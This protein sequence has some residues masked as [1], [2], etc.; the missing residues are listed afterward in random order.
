MYLHKCTLKKL[1][2]NYQEKWENAYLTVKN[3]RGVGPQPILAGFAHQTPLRYVGKIL[4]KISVP[5]DEILDPLL[6]PL[7]YL[8]ALYT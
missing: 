5:L 1:K 8:V 3:A 4:Q 6:H 2:E 7:L